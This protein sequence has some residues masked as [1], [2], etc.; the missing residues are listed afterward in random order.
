MRSM[1]LAFALGVWALQQ[2]ARL[3]EAAW[4]YLPILLAP[5]LLLPEGGIALRRLRRLLLV[6]FAATLGFGYA[7]FVA[8]QRLADGLPDAWQ[9]RDIELIGVVAELPRQHIRG[10]S[11]AFDVERTLT[12]EAHVP[13]H[14]LLSTYNNDKEPPLPL[15]AGERWQLTVRLKQPHD[16]A[17]PNG[18]DFEQWLLERNLRASGYVRKGQNTRL[19]ATAGAPG[20]RIEQWRETAR[21]R[22]QRILGDRPSAGVLTAL[23]IGD[24]SAIPQSQWQIFTRTGTN[25]LISISGLHITMLAG[26]AFAAVYWLWRHSTRLTLRLPARKAAA[27]ASLA[28][29][30]LYVLLSGNSIPAQRTLYMLAAVAAALF[31]SRALAPSQLL[32]LALLTVV[33]LDPWAV[34]SP[35]CWLSF[36]AVA[37]IFYVTANRVGTRHWLHEFL[38]VQWA[39]TIG[40]IPLTLALFQQVSVVSPLANAFAIPLISLLVVPL[41][42][43]GTALPLDWPLLLAQQIMQT[44]ID[45]LGWLSRLPEAVWIQHAPPV[46][47]ILLGAAGA[48]W[49]LLPR[50]F[51]ARWLGALAMLPMFLV[52]APPPPEGQLRLTVFDVGQGTA[53]AAQTRNHALLYDTGPDFSGESDSGNRI[54]LPALRAQGI[55]ELDALILTHDD[56]DHTG[57]ARSVL[58]GMPIREAYSSLPPDHPL[59][60]ALPQTRH[61]MDGQ[62]WEWDGVR[63]DILHPTLESYAWDDLRDNDRGCVL[64]IQTG[65]YSVLLAADIEQRSERRLLSVHP[66]ELPATVLVVPHH[67]S[68]TS[69]GIP[70]VETVHPQEAIFTVGYRNRFNHPKEE[71]VERYRTGGSRIWRSD[72]EGALQISMSKNGVAIAPYRNTHARYWLHAAHESAVAH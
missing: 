32:A 35:G 51:S 62:Q 66:S 6:V 26:F 39:I 23:A 47:S 71:I 19:D 40:L 25:H 59:R 64:R 18:F 52:G 21:E 30:C 13:A 3:P 63:F 65:A 44:G 38:H 1:I 43:L 4:G 16:T 56:I 29:A 48:V 61:C 9:G 46:W 60:V 10:L 42:L 58:E 28:I 12:P 50:G 69:S 27:L 5:A 31:W 22:L 20:Y 2:Q 11:F 70:F 37:L 24:Q 67:G 45:A 54:L 55:A 36:G 41:T 15:R 49:L 57:G 14:I 7:A 17:N 8:Q 33:A 72:R 68:Q 34:L 53:I